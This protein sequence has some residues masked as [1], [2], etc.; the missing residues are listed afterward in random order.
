MDDTPVWEIETIG[1][2]LLE[3]LMLDRNIDE[4]TATDLFYT[5]GTFARL[6]DK[7]TALYLKPWTEIYRLLLQELK[8]ID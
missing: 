6:I 5:S 8:N 7:T 4:A 3:T 2:S 1:E